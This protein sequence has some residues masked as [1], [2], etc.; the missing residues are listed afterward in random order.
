MS[1]ANNNQAANNNVTDVEEKKAGIFSRI[2][3]AVTSPLAKTIGVAV[4]SA[5][6]GAAGGYYFAKGKGCRVG[7]SADEAKD[8][9][10]A[11]SQQTPGLVKA[12]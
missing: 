1:N 7:M 5:G 10:T 3:A 11:V 2:R 9:V 6:A 4:V 12:K 8:I